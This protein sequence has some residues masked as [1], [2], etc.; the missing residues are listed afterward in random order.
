MQ[1]SWRKVEVH[2]AEGLVRLRQVDVT[3]CIECGACTDVCPVAFAMDEPPAELM[4]RAKRGEGL[5]LLGRTS[6]WVC[7]DCRHCSEACPVGIDVARAMEGLRLLAYESGET[8][9][10]NPIVRLHD[11]F[12]DEVGE[13]G[14]LHELSFLWRF[15]HA[16]TDWRSRLGLPA[17]LLARGR[18]PVRVSRPK[19]WPGLEKLEPEAERQGDAN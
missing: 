18:L 14:R 11:V 1:D 16:I 13:R 17:V 10:D 4:T 6:L 5:E 7:T 12:M 9:A 3:P 19:S 8:P 15:R 2:V